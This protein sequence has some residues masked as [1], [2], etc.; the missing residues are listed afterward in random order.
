MVRFQRILCPVDFFPASLR[1]FDYALKLARTYGGRVDVLHV[2]SRI[3]PAVPETLVRTSDMTAKLAKESKRE[4]QKLEAKGSKAHVPVRTATTIG[5]IDLQ[6]LGA[7]KQKKSDLLVMGTHGRRRF[8]RWVMG[9]VAERMLRYSPIPLLIV[10][11]ATRVLS[12]PP[13]IRRILVTT[14]FSEGTPDALAHAF[15]IAQECRAK[16]TL[17]HVVPDLS[18]A[19]GLKVTRPMIAGVRRNL[20]ELVPADARPRCDVSTRVE[21]GEAAYKVILKLIK[22]ERP[23]LVV[24]NT[25]GKG[26]VERVLVGSTA[27]RVVR[28]ASASCPVLL[29]P[30][31]GSKKA[32]YSKGTSPRRAA[33]TR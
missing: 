28:G 30:P 14:D 31:M 29:I 24:M 18:S 3:I 4:L 1:A 2:I 7:A 12:G 23:E 25:H 21:A 27:E 22:T 32:P 13:S 11:S 15:S 26:M 19:I 10:G 5:D 17:L 16:I 20:D 33:P 9:S 8:E 6:I